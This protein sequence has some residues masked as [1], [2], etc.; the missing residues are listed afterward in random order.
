MTIEVVL[1]QLLFVLM[2]TG[3]LVV[4]QCN[5]LLPIFLLHPVGTICHCWDGVCFSL[6]LSSMVECIF[7][8][9]M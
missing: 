6:I 7:Q 2:F 4:E 5:F 3:V 9:V 1:L 8:G